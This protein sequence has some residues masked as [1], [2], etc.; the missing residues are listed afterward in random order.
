METK[1]GWLNQVTLELA[2]M[3]N[4]VNNK[5]GS[6]FV[7]RTYEDRNQ[8]YSMDKLD[9]LQMKPTLE[10]P[11]P[12]IRIKNR[13]KEKEYQTLCHIVR[14]LETYMLTARKLP[15]DFTAVIKSKFIDTMNSGGEAQGIEIDPL[16]FRN[17]PGLGKTMDMNLEARLIRLEL[18]QAKAIHDLNNSMATSQIRMKKAIAEMEAKKDR[19]MNKMQGLLDTII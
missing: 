3:R 6:G 2:G 12:F 4:P 5:P 14:E 10:C 7:I 1:N 11:A 13:I 19:A 15:T 17:N 9:A 18:N 16:D 8:I